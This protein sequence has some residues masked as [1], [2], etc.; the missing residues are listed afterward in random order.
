VAVYPLEWK[1]SDARGDYPHMAKNDA[2][3]WERFLD[4]YGPNFLRFA[5][6]VA[7][8]GFLPEGDDTDK[9]YRV[10][11]Q[12]STALKIDALGERVDDLWVIEVRPSAGV[13]AIGAAL[14]YT[15]LA[16]L[17]PLATKPL[18]PVVVTD[19]TSP[20]IQLCAE[21]FNVVVIQ[22]DVKP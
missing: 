20:D 17:D 8:G 2:V 15:V 7:L 16:S 19:R 4:E 21:A 18:Q 3:L 11:H 9:Q 5:Y 12:Y 1:L 14:C 10:G 6:D 22:L 13:S